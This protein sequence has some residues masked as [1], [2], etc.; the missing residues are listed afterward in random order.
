MLIYP[1]TI[2]LSTSTLTF[3]TRQLRAHRV[4]IPSPWRKLSAHRQALL[5]LAYLRNGDTLHGWSPGLVSGWPPSTAT[6]GRR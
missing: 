3:L 2:T 4:A 6:S 5:V 1:A